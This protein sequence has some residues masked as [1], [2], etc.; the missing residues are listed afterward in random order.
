MKLKR[1]SFFAFCFSL[2]PGAAHMYMG[3]MKQ[4][5]SIM[6]LLTI[7][8]AVAAMLNLPVITVIIPIIWFYAFFDAHHKRAL[9]EHEF[10]KLEDKSIFSDI[11]G[12]D[13][14]NLT[15]GKSRPILA[16]FLIFFGCYIIYD[17]IINAM[18]SI[19]PGF[20]YNGFYNMFRRL[21]QILVA[22]LII[23]IGYRL[24]KGKKIELLDGFN[25]KDSYENGNNNTNYTE[26]NH[27]YREYMNYT[28]GKDN[29]NEMGNNYK[30]MNSTFSKMKN[31][32]DTFDEK[33]F[34][35]EY[36]IQ[37]TEIEVG[38]KNE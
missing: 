14:V 29:S 28:K 27:N 11:T 9:P 3:F 32:V 1:N 6:I 17:Y 38:D 23:Y 8:I 18:F 22:L 19:M 7:D 12:T 25:N 4:G 13:L 15:K 24:I 30:E 35:M 26:E 2:I 37:A 10:N 36:E 21:P 16:G 31:E 34:P 5:M 20:L 33:S